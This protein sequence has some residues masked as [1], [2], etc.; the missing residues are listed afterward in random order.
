MLADGLDFV[1]GV[2]T[3]RDFHTLAVLA[4]RSG[5]IVAEGRV[6]ASA[7]GYAA[8]LRFAWEHGRGR[9]AWAIEG[10]GSYGAGLARFLEG[11]G[12]RVLEVDRPK[13]EGRSP[14]K[15][16]PLD[17]VRAARTLLGREKLALPRAGGRREA[18]RALVSTREG[19]LRAKRAGLCQ[20]RALIVTLPEPLR[21][22]LRGLT[23][24]PLL[25]RC[26]RLRPQQ[27]ADADA[28]GALVALRA[29]AHRVQ[30]LTEEERA[31]KREIAHLVQAIAPQLLAEPGVG[32]ITA[33]QVLI[34]WSHKGRLASDAC[35][36]RLGGAAPIPASTGE[37]VRQRLDRGGDRQ[38]NRA[39]H[40]I[41]LARRKCHPATNAY[42]Q[43]RQQEGKTTREAIRCLKRYLARHLYRLLEAM[44]QAA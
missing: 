17:A 18:L 21:G 22:E 33:A 6:G 25:A 29:L 31:L 40:T 16:D 27:R 23:R 12:E 42:I 7:S 32:P 43:R 28:R 44:P 13:R 10:T 38:L 3:H 9:R 14:A 30:A 34:A 35:F 37:H 2:D 24:A 19:A 5:G 15:S 26:A 11:E 1:L 36:A 20:L 8:A 4:C 39:R 41:I